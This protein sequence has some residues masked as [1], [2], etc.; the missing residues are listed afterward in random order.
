MAAGGDAVVCFMAEKKSPY[1]SSWTLRRCAF[2]CET[3]YLYYTSKALRLNSPWKTAVKLSAVHVPAEADDFDVDAL[4]RFDNNTD[5][6]RSERNLYLF[7][8]HGVYRNTVAHSS[9]PT[10]A[11]PNALSFQRT[12]RGRP[13]RH[14]PRGDSFQHDKTVLYTWRCDSAKLL[15]RV[16][17]V[18]RDVLADDGLCPPVNEGLPLYDPRNRIP[19]AHVPLYLGRPFRGLEKTVFYAFERGDLV[20]RSPAGDVGT[21]VS[22]GFLCLT[23]QTVLLIRSDG[24]VPR[25][26]AITGIGGV[27]YNTRKAKLPFIGILSSA[28]SS[29]ADIVFVPSPPLRTSEERRAYRESDR[30]LE[31]VELLR[32]VSAFRCGRA[33]TVTEDDS[34]S[35]R[36]Y[37]TG[38]DSGR[39]PLRFAPKEG[40]REPLTLPLPKAELARMTVAAASEATL[41]PPPPRP[42][43]QQPP[44]TGV[45]SK[46]IDVGDL[47]L[48]PTST[49]HARSTP[50]AD[51]VAATNPHVDSS[52]GGKRAE[53]KQRATAAAVG[54]DSVELSDSLE[55]YFLDQR[56]TGGD[57]EAS[58]GAPRS[59]KGEMS[60]EQLINQSFAA[61]PT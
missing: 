51:D 59:R 45:P 57:H 5:G 28:S 3:R 25:W 42:P 7:Q 50:A 2:D 34:P 4:F 55:D 36:A 48:Y 54:V 24:T 17:D 22:G 61:Y 11:M 8:V 47:E 27:E 40:V 26:T 15:H 32:R 29:A 56:P 1:T 10:D 41:P 52:G 44:L 6:D 38:K 37:I 30:V 12:H 39:R 20:G 23:D 46:T 49:G 9:P 43:G 16:V 35:V 33:L 18:M 53:E 60:L 21:A 14:S 31:L 58:R 19:L 13:S